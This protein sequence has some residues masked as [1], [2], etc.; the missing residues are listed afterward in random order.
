MGMME[1]M[2][3]EVVVLFVFV[4]FCFPFLFSREG[5]DLAATLGE[6]E[7]MGIVVIGNHNWFAWLCG[8]KVV[9][10]EPMCT[11]IISHYDAVLEGTVFMKG[12]FGTVPGGGDKG[13]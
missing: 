4:V 6:T 5:G 2:S 11:C 12:C 9:D 1:M 3:K 8:G 10:G 7:T 13:G